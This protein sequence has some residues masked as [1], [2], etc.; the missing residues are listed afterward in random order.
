MLTAGSARAG[1]SGLERFLTEAFE[2]GWGI[3]I[4]QGLVPA[5]PGDSRTVSQLL[6]CCAAQP[7]H[8]AEEGANTIPSI[9]GT[10]W[11]RLIRREPVLAPLVHPREITAVFSGGDVFFAIN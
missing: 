9:T 10:E 4:K 8:R 5:A 2:L 3:G 6:C 1:A 7:W 11:G